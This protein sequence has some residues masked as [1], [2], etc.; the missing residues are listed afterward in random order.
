MYLTSFHWSSS[1]LWRGPC[2]SITEYSSCLW[3]TSSLSLT[4]NISQ[5]MQTETKTKP[6]TKTE[7][8][9][10]TKVLPSIAAA[11][12]PPPYFPCHTTFH[13]AFKLKLKLNQNPKLKFKLKLSPSI[14]PPY[15]PQH[16]IFQAELKLYL[17]V[18]KTLT[19]INNIS[20]QIETKTKP[21]TKTE[22][23]AKT[24]LSPSIPAAFEPPPYFRW[25]TIFHGELK[26]NFKVD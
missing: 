11:F 23:K 9:A 13:S 1:L 3:E 18:T 7:I 21:N 5:W 12:E 24:K 14:L 8:K 10:Q 4:H 6:K 20:G 25:H 16:T 2:S 17:K 19:N 22:I 26:L 15:F